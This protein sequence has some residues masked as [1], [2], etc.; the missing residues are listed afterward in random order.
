MKQKKIRNVIVKKIDNIKYLCDDIR[1]GFE[2]DD[3][4]KF[5]TTVKALRSFLRLQQ[6]NTGT[7]MKVTRKFKRLYNI[8]GEIREAQLELEFLKDIQASIPHYTNHLHQI[9]WQSKQEWVKTDVKKVMHKLQEKLTGYTYTTLKPETVLAFFN[10]RMAPINTLVAKEH[11]ASSEIHN[12]RKN[13]KDILYISKIADKEWKTVSNQAEDLPVAK[14]DKL[15]TKI[16]EYNDER[17]ISE[18]LE[19]FSLLNLGRKE[20]SKMEVLKTDEALKL[21]TKKKAF[22]ATARGELGN[23]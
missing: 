6:M 5:R 3:I 16:G 23:I 8:A 15:A 1:T 22:I 19:A 14:L 2:Q 21:E 18:H 7:R 12:A 13:I 20:K 11:P 10:D 4:H 9:I 17:I